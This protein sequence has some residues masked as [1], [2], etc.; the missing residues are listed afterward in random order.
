MHDDAAT[1]G[2]GLVMTL[3]VDPHAGALARHAVRDTLTAAGAERWLEA[4]EL[5]VTEVVTNAVLHARGPIEL[6]VVVAHD[7]TLVEVEDATT[8]LPALRGYGPQATTGRGLSM[9]TA[10]T[11]ACGARHVGGLDS[12]KVVWFRVDD[13]V[14]EADDPLAAWDDPDPADDDL[15]A[16][17]VDVRLLALPV[18]RWLEAR[19]QHDALLRELVLHLVRHPDDAPADAVDLALGERGRGTIARALA[20]VATPGRPL[21]SRVDLTVPVDPAL[22]PAFR[23]L[24]SALRVAER[25]AVDQ[26]LLVPPSVPELV[27]LRDWVVGQIDDQCAGAAPVAWA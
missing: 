23:A 2:R 17:H 6:R 5:A 10:V 1:A 18:H 12:G 22:V 20:A 11:S 4:T 19:Q 9:V 15:P 3:P 13:D 16:D 14:Q 7:H 27:A 21:P 26:R 25:L 8:V 24:Q